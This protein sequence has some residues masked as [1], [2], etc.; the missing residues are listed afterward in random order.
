MHAYSVKDCAREKYILAVT[1]LAIGFVAI[2]NQAAGAIGVKVSVGTVSAFG[3]AF[4]VFDRW[5]WRWPFVLRF[6][7]IPDLAGTWK[8]TGRTSGADGVERNWEAE[9]RIEQSWS[10]IA[11]SIETTTSR[12]RSSMAAA[13]RDAGHGFRLLYGY[14]NEPKMAGSELRSHR[15]TCE[16]VFNADLTTGQGTY[17]NDHQC[18]TV[19]EM[20]WTRISQNGAQK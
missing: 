18:R 13:E 8:I 19:G 10:R 3:V 20:I 4:F 11:I 17:F 6:V 7:A 16:V 9:A 1:L 14:T 15:G 5:A 2:A 12:S